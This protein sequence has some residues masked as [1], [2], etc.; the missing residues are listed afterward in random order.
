MVC[1]KWYE[2]EHAVQN[3]RRWCWEKNKGTD[4]PVFKCEESQLPICNTMELLGVKID[5]KLNFEK[6]MA[7]IV[8]K[9]VNR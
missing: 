3:T 2:E 1:A 9:S 5:E 6:H 7:K 4:E 8:E